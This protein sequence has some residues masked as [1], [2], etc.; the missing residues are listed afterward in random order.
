M[1]VVPRLVKWINREEWCRVYKSLYSMKERQ[2]GVEQIKVWKARGKIPL[3]VEC[4]GDLVE[5]EFYE[6]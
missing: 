1:K 5:V 6:Q 3:A 2:W 4:T